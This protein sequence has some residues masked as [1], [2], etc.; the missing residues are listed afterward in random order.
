MGTNFSE[1]F[2]PGGTNFRGVRI[3]CD[4]STRPS[5]ARKQSLV[6]A[7]KDSSELCVPST[8]IHVCQTVSC[9][10]TTVSPS[11]DQDMTRTSRFFVRPPPFIGPPVEPPSS[12][13]HTL[14]PSQEDSHWVSFHFQQSRD[15][16]VWVTVVGKAPSSSPSAYILLLMSYYGNTATS[17]S[18]NQVKM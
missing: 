1:K 12:H 17:S 16:L 15:E 14:T 6:V 2:V 18:E 13:P 4:R 7:W 3:K 5:L 9:C 10:I 11:R 8:S